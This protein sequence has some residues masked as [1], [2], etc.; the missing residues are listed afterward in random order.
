[1]D[2][3]G[4]LLPLVL[5]AAV[6]YLLILRPARKRQQQQRAT[7][8]ALAPGQE[9]MTASG[10]FGRVSEVAA[11]R[12]TVEIAAGVEIQV[13]PAAISQVIPATPADAGEAVGDSESP[14]ADHVDLADDDV[15]LARD[16]APADGDTPTR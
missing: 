3:L 7:I 5:L 15:E 6:F 12:I 13:L 1:V 11:D 2:S 10:I 4:A 16:P 9:V 8:S 14:A